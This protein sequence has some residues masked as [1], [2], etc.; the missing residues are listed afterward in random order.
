ME[1]QQ[2]FM[3][4]INKKKIKSIVDE[5][6][7]KGFVVIP[8][9]ISKKDSSNFCKQLN[10]DFKKYSKFYASPGKV[11]KKNLQSKALE[12]T[13]FNLHNKNINWFKLFEHPLIIQILDI[14]LKEG[15]YNNKEPYYLNNISARSPLKNAHNQQLHI[16][17]GLP[18]VNYLLKVNALW[19]LNDFNKSNGTTTVLP[20]SHKKKTYPEDNKIYNKLNYI[21]AQ[22]GSVIIFDGS[23]WHG[24]SGGKI[25]DDDRWGL[26]LG[27][28]RWWIKPSFDFTKNTPSKIFNKLNDSQK[29]LLGFHLT[30]PK[31]EFTRVRRISDKFEKP[32]KYS[33]PK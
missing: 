24:G 5:V 18:G 19:C 27:Y 6:K 29:K 3:Q 8:N 13:V 1:E 30:S 28:A 14:L 10:D 23:L 11:K 7:Q 2:L 20:G 15:S 21:N 12:K 33:L 16:D 9:L 32:I 22:A 25:I 31:D 17:S 26:I 4:K